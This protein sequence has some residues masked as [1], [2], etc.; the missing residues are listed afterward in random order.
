VSERVSHDPHIGAA[1]F[2]GFHITR[3]LAEQSVRVVGLD[4]FNDY[5][6]VHLKHD[7]AQV[8]IQK[9]SKLVKL[10]HNGEDL[11]HV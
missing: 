6:D 3:R 11:N 8:L 2:I 7:R 1:G 10:V 9:H 5:Y 4:N